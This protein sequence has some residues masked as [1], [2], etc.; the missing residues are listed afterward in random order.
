MVVV[1]RFQQWLI[2][3]YQPM[4]EITQLL[5]FFINDMLFDNFLLTI[6]VG[7]KR[8]NDVTKWSFLRNYVRDQ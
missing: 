1:D 3:T 5:I 7:K 4:V 8:Y 6:P 2:K